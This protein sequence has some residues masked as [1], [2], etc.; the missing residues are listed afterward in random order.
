MRSLYLTVLSFCLLGSA[1]P[2]APS[3]SPAPLT[4]VELKKGIALKIEIAD[5]DSLRE[6]GLSGRRTLDWNQGM[7]FVFPDVAPRSFWMIDCHFDIDVAYLTAKGVIRDIVPMHIQPGVPVDQLERYVSST[8]DIAYALETNR[9]WFANQG[10]KEGDTLATLT[11]WK[12]R[13]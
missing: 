9:G 11:R 2:A 10:I 3:A 4:K 7:L 8:G 13:R 5:N 6:R 12:T 1:L